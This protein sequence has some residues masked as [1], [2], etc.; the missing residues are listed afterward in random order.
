MVLG[1]S[2]FVVNFDWTK[3]WSV[4]QYNIVNYYSIIQVT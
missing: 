3:V 1:L 2:A 4:F